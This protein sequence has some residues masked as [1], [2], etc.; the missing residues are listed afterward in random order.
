MTNLFDPPKPEA[1]IVNGI[2]VMIDIE[3]M[4][5]STTAPVISI[6][7]AL[8]DPLK[9]DTWD[10]L[11]ARSFYRGIE[12]TDAIKH[13]SGVEGGTL[14]WWLQQ[15]DEAI[16]R[17]VTGD[18][19][20]LKVA[21]ND[22]FQYCTSR[23]EKGPLVGIPPAEMVWANSPNFDCTILEASTKAVGLLWP[24]KFFNYRDVRTLKDI[25]WPNGP[26]DVPKLNEGIAHGAD[27]DACAQALL[28]QEAYRTM[29][30]A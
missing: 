9:N 28:V 3:T 12:L 4:G 2:A 19:V 5:T 26:E 21:L 18:L 20:P 23:P 1:P 13:S 25:A 24:F 16:K 11:K 27:D 7:A 15:K 22:L 14:T 6:G 30:L 29:R 10:T 17:L 8:F